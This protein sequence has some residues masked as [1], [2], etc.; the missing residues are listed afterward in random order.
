[1]KNKLNKSNT[2]LNWKFK[3]NLHIEE[4]K[5]YTEWVSTQRDS[6]KNISMTISYRIMKLPE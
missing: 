2:D 4:S 6:S 1:M 3:E 5:R